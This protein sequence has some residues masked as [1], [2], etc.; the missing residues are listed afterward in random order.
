MAVVAMQNPI[1]KD[2]AAVV[3]AKLLAK[4]GKGSD[5]TALAKII[6]NPIVRDETLL[7]L[8]KP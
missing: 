2:D 7:E 8:S 4:V 6:Q 1:K 5:A 3:S